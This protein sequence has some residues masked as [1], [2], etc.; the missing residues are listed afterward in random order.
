M[1]ISDQFSSATTLATGIIVKDKSGKR[2]LSRNEGLIY[3]FSNIAWIIG[4]LIAGYISNKFGFNLIFTLAAIF[5]FIAFLLFKLSKIKGI[6]FA[7]TKGKKV[8]YIKFPK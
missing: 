7:R 4:P 1:V 8:K 5:L 3:T 2:Q 6:V